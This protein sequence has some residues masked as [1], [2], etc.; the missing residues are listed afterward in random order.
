MTV[1]KKIIPLVCMLAFAAIAT[2]QQKN[3]VILPTLHALHRVA[4][5]YTYDSLKAAITW[6]QPEVI[7]VEI[8]PE[9]IDKD[10]DYLKKNYPYEAWMM[11]YWFPQA[12]LVGF[13]WLGEDIEGKPIPDGYWEGPTSVKQWEKELA[14]DTLYSKRAERCQVYSLQRVN[15]LVKSSLADILDNDNDAI[16]QQ[17]HYNCLSM[18]LRGSPHYRIM[19]FYDKR[20]SKMQEN[21]KQQLASFAG[22][23]VV[24]VTGDE[25]YPFLK[26]RLG[27]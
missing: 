10:S 18:Q 23:R 2:A 11:R 13:D 5:R 27:L 24:I 19:Q 4:P 9:D 7:A 12:K 25:H 21:L 14:A 17:E 20:N 15:M 6:L 8:R 16:L 22:R 26:K 3:T 1:M